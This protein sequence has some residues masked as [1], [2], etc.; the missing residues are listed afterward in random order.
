MSSQLFYVDGTDSYQQGDIITTYSISTIV[1]RSCDF[2][3]PD[4]FLLFFWSIVFHNDL[5]FRIL[6]SNSNS[7]RLGIL[8]ESD[9]A[10]RTVVPKE[11]AKLTFHFLL[12]MS[13]GH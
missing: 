9:F 7:H 2:G 1:I 6:L 13:L 8:P 3:V 4:P 10:F 12:D 5:S 11:F